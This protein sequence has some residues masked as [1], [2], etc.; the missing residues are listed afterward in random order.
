MTEHGTSPCCHLT[1]GW[2][3]QGQAPKSCRQLTVQMTELQDSWL[4]TTFMALFVVLFNVEFWK[5][6]E[7]IHFICHTEWYI[8]LCKDSMRQTWLCWL[9]S[10]GRGRAVGS[11]GGWQLEPITDVSWPPFTGFWHACYIKAMPPTA[12]PDNLQHW[13]CYSGGKK[14]APAPLVICTTC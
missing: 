4:K 1:G 2:P 5:I 11:E 9:H 13:H 14:G 3:Q 10:L 8:S 12:V 6:W 7:I